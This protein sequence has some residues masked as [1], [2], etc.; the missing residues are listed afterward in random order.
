[1]AVAPHLQTRKVLLS[2]TRRIAL[3]AHE[4][5]LN[6]RGDCR[7]AHVF[8]RQPIAGLALEPV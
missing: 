2:L 8:L 7:L 6:A 5:T 4:S 3:N 1:M